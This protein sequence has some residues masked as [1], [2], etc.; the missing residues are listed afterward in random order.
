MIP[1][2]TGVRGVRPVVNGPAWAL[3]IE[4]RAQLDKNDGVSELTDGGSND[5]D[6]KCS[7][8]PHCR[9]KI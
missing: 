4:C 7:C 3:A 2:P 6:R 9:I 5:R 1:V 8:Q